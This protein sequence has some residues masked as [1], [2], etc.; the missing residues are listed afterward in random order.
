MKVL[1][2]GREGQLARSLAERAASREGIELVAIGRPEL[3]LEVA[4]SSARAIADVSPDVVINA[5]AYTAVD[6]AEDEPARAFRINADAAGE[7][8]EGARKAGA[9]IIQMSTDYVFDGRSAVPY[10]ENSATNPIN[11]YGRSKLA[12]EE[13]V[14]AANP[15][16]LIVRTSW[17]YSP[18]GRNFVKSIMAAAQDRDV[19]T[20]V[21]DQ[22]GC[23]SSA[24]DVAEIILTVVDRWRQ[25]ERVGRGETYHLAGSGSTSWCGFAQAIMEHCG[26]LG[27]PTAEVR[28]I[29]TEDW[30]TKAVRP[31]NSTLHCK[32][33]ARDFGHALP[34]WRDSLRAVIERIALETSR[35]S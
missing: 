30:P 7:V 20:V 18:F 1:V 19:L 33:F 35:A 22:R 26:A 29:R 12:G 8:A 15:D 10:S 23:P 14:R 31:Q 4:G 3:D 21:D 16:H 2:T 17:V 24:L 6:H 13:H 34:Q 25:G 28:P 11:V 9:A 5:A 32:K 27:L